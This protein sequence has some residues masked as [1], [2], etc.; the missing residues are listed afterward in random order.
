MRIAWPASAVDCWRH[1]ETGLVSEWETI[2]GQ[3]PLEAIR[4]FG[5]TKAGQLLVQAWCNAHSTSRLAARSEKRRL[6]AFVA[7]QQRRS[8]KRKK[9]AACIFCTAAKKKCLPL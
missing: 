5:K 1:A 9:K 2:R 7:R 3:G 8:K 4:L 6:P